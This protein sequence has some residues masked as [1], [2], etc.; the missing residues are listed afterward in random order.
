M[1]A[2]KAAAWTALWT[3]AAVF[4]LGCIGFLSD[5]Q[6]WASDASRTAFPSVQ[7]VAKA[8][9]SGVAAALAGLLNFVYRFA[10]S[11]GINLPGKPATYIENKELAKA[12][13]AAPAHQQ[14]L[15]A[16]YVLPDVANVANDPTAVPVEGFLKGDAR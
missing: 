12:V 5:V 2:L 3:F 4:G 6:A 1:D 9:A 14:A 7:P 11:K 10:Q 8:A 16:G 15:I 13:D